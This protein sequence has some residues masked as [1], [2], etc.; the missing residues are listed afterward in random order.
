M[1]DFLIW[2]VFILILGVIG[3]PLSYTILPH[4]K[5]R[6]YAVSKI[7]T[8]LV[9]GYLFWILTIL[10]ILGNNLGGVVFAL[11]AFAG[12][13]IWLYAKKFAEIN[14]WVKTNWQRVA[15]TEAVFIIA[16]GFWAV[17]RAAN[18]NLSGTEK[19]M[20]LAFINAILKS[21]GFPPNDPWL[22]GYSISY[23]YF[24]YVIVS[25][26]I[27]MTGVATTVAFN[28]MI[29]L[30]FGLVAV[31][32]FG[33][34]NN[35]L[36]RKQEQA[37][38]KKLSPLWGILA[39]IFILVLGNVQGF[40]EMLHSSGVGW[41]QNLDGSWT[42][43]FWSWLNMPEVENPPTLPLQIAPKRTN[44]YW[45][46]RSSRVV[47]D[48][49]ASGSRSEMIDEFP[50]FSYI[51]ADMHPHVLAM[52][53]ALLAITIALNIYFGAVKNT[54]GKMGVFAWLKERFL[55]DNS[56]KTPFSE[57]FIA[58]WLKSP[59]FWLMT[60]ACGGMAFFNTWDYPVYVGLFALAVLIHNTAKFGWSYRRVS[61]F[62]ETGLLT[63][64]L[65]VILYLPFFLGFDSQAG[66]FLPSISFFTRGKYFWIM[67]GT[68]L[69]PLLI[70]L[71]WFAGK[72]KHHFNGK[73]GVLGACGLVFGLWLLSYLIGA[74]F[75]YV[76]QLIP[77]DTITG[78][79]NLFYWL[80]GAS[81][82]TTLLMGSLAD[83]FKSPLTWL[84]LLFGLYLVWGLL[85][86]KSSHQQE[87]AAPVSSPTNP[88]RFV[89]LLV[90]LGLGL[91]L[92]PEFIYLR[93]QFGIRMNTIFKFYFQAWILW[94]A[95]A[96]YATTIIWTRIRG[97][98]SI[99]AKPASLF[100]ILIG[101]VFPVYAIWDTTSHFSPEIYNY[102]TG[103][104]EPGWTLDGSRS[105]KL[106]LPDEMDAIA[107]L[108]E[109]PVGV[110][111]EAI[112]GQ[113]SDYARVSTY[114]GQPTV[115][116][117]PGHESQ[118]RGG[119][120]EMGTRE[121][122]IEVLYRSN[123]WDLVKSVLDQYQI[124]YV[125]FGDLERDKYNA[126]SNIFDT[127]LTKLIVFGNVTIYGYTPASE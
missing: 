35:I 65:G 16:F 46:W 99:L 31:S 116:G 48:F 7:L 44:G 84:T 58:Q 5:D 94:G 66:G 78:L 9:W 85:F 80:Q 3:F 15:L 37:G 17:V 97:A 38:E 10:G 96:A 54:E 68:L 27:R 75:L 41:A 13:N 93:D 20:E 53:F 47:Q 122:D 30:L 56:E 23:Y 51:L 112:G 79:T 63:G 103:V 8:L 21:P 2:L 105:R 18:P 89:L 55:S 114:S 115:L 12:L 11:L 39:P 83:R 33:L 50:Q 25:M 82:G 14:Q 73:V 107:W 61:E 91:T 77:S 49:T 42:S 62:L 52:P 113:Y 60:L 95:A 86:D 59:V 1:I 6:G 102:Q 125:F 87:E 28:L 109:Q 110:V 98:V 67:F 36:A 124:T 127:Y 108:E 45:W 22:S 123:N 119:N 90:L 24:G 118:W 104:V 40:L 57:L 81:D 101:M 4:L 43:R 71:I 34:L 69:V 64:I 72:R 88:D 126:N 106:A 117:W 26:L 92:V 70:W 19:P 120:E 121:T 100:M 76:G 74:V 111:A 29:A 32:A